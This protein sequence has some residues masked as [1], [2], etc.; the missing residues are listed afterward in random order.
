MAAAVAQRLILTATFDDTGRWPK[1]F[2]GLMNGCHAAAMKAAM[3]AGGQEGSFSMMAMPAAGREAADKMMEIGAR[4]RRRR[5]Y[6]RR[7]RCRYYH[8]KRDVSLML[9]HAPAQR[10]RPRRRR[11]DYHRG[12]D[13]DAS[14]FILA[15]AM[16][17]AAG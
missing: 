2:L 16:P 15:A 3:S 11:S 6:R 13:D 12:S 4:I 1:C 10:R 7:H 8:D 5:R 14:R 17:A 9:A